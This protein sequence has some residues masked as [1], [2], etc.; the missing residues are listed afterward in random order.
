MVIESTTI[1]PST[2]IAKILDFAATRNNGGGSVVAVGT[3]KMCKVPVMIPTLSFTGPRR[4]TSLLRAPI[5]EMTYTVSSG[6][7]N[8]S[9]PYHTGPDALPATQPTVGIMFCK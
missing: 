9:I 5:S 2:R 8:S 7:L 6:T 3:L 1:S 4:C